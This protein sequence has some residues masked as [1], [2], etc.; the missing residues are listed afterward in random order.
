M[1]LSLGMIVGAGEL[2]VGAFLPG[3][4]IATDGA[5]R[6]ARSVFLTPVVNEVM[7]PVVEKVG[8]ALDL[9]GSTVGELAKD[10]YLNKTDYAEL[11]D[12]FPF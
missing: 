8:G 3:S 12:L 5:F 2:I 4:G 6:I 9:D 11:A 1:D 10:L 7:A